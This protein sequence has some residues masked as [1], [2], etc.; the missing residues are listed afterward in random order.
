MWRTW[1]RDSN[2][3]SGLNMRL[4]TIHATLLALLNLS[5]R[6][7]CVIKLFHIFTSWL[8]RLKMCRNCFQSTLLSS[9]LIDSL[10]SRCLY[11]MSES[12]MQKWSSTRRSAAWAILPFLVL[13]NAVNAWDYESTRKVNLIAT[14]IEQKLAAQFCTKPFSPRLVQSV[15]PT[16]DR[17]SEEFVTSSLSF[18]KALSG[19]RFSTLSPVTED[20]MDGLTG[21]AITDPLLTLG[22]A[23]WS[24]KS[25]YDSLQTSSP[26]LQEKTGE[27]N[28]PD[29]GY[30][31][32]TYAVS[33][34]S[35]GL[36]DFTHI[37]LNSHSTP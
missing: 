18:C 28:D 1:V 29:R 23:I 16:L 37:L 24:R 30:K 11:C 6:C 20:I 27:D 31:N 25:W 2:P 34:F 3:S 35:L 15:D 13:S 32:G 36:Y 22:P 7:I 17:V 33:M 19:L 4:P 8:W 26:R 12:L 14:L 9:S 5:I 10:A 21:D